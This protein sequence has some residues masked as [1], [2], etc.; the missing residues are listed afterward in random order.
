MLQSC[1]ILR[2]I[3]KSKRYKLTKTHLLHV[4]GYPADNDKQGH[5]YKGVGRIRKV[6]ETSELGC[7]VYH[8][9]DTSGGKLWC[10]HILST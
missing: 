3:P 5:M 6:E 1:S 4:R 7:I 9:V 2:H 8:D 10:T